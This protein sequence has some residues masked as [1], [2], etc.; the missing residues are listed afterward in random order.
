[1]TI[2]KE[3]SLLH[4]DIQSIQARCY[5]HLVPPSFWRHILV[6]FE[7]LQR[8]PNNVV[9]VVV[10]VVVVLHLISSVEKSILVPFNGSNGK[11]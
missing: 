1:M 4:S 3:I 8:G 2:S 11:K 7:I 9:V 10:V 5:V 6:N